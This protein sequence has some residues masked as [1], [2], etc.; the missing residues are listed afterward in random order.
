M[1]HHTLTLATAEQVSSLKASHYPAGIAWSDA[2]PG[3][4]A[5]GGDIGE[6]FKSPSDTN[7]SPVAP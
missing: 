3:F 7:W 2:Q 5:C 4:C 1:C 6:R